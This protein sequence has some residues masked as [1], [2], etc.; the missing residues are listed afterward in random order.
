MYHFVMTNKKVGRNEPCP[1]GSGRK[2]KKCCLE[3]GMFVMEETRTGPKLSNEFRD[4]LDRQRAEVDPI[5]AETERVGE[6]VM[7]ERDTFV[8]MRHLQLQKQLVELDAQ[9]NKADA[10]ILA[11]SID[12]IDALPVSEGRSF[13]LEFMA[14]QV[15]KT[16]KAVENSVFPGVNEVTL[17]ALELAVGFSGAKAAVEGPDSGNDQLAPEIAPEL[18]DDDE[19]DEELDDNET[20]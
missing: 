5:K 8:T 3:E 4:N 9:H 2:Y 20:V 13:V 15:E 7:L 1:C 16:L 11:A 14:Q 19:L 6:A 17:H 12:E 18:V 10:D